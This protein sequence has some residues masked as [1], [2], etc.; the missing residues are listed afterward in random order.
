M[1][2]SAFAAVFA[3]PASAQVTLVSNLA[4]TSGTTGA[5]S[6]GQVVISGTARTFVRAQRFMTGDNEDGYALSEVTAELRGVG[7]NSLPKVSLYSRSGANPGTSLYGL[8]N[9]A[10]IING[11]NSFTVPTGITLSLAKETD[12]LSRGFRTRAGSTATP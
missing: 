6:V 3:T 2:L 1:L 5:A 8:T 11:L 10:S 12:Y 4:Q 9:P 7:A